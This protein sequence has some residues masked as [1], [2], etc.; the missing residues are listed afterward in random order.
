MMTPDTASR[1]TPAPTAIKPRTAATTM[2]S[3]TPR[4]RLN[5]RRSKYIVQS[6][7]FT[8]RDWNVCAS[9]NTW[10]VRGRNVRPRRRGVFYVADEVILARSND[11]M[12]FN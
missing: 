3:L 2:R 6:F 8:T 1:E 7:G 5:K 12:R 11:R 10:S 4:V 9:R